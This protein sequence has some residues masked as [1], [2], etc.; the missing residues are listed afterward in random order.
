VGNLVLLKGK[1]VKGD[2]EIHGVI[3]RFTVSCN[4]F[5]DWLQS[6]TAAGETSRGK[7]RERNTRSTRSAWSTWSTWNTW[8][9]CARKKIDAGYRGYILAK[10][11][12]P[13]LF[14]FGS[15]G[16]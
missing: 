16:L 8:N 2:E 9:A 1:E 11:I 12:Y 10:R 4:L 5:V 14:G 15:V 13:L 7:R 6:I 3:Y